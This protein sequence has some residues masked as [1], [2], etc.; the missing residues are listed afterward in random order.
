M[1]TK[2]KL[3]IKVDVTKEVKRIAR[4]LVG[5]VPASRVENTKETKPARKE[6]Y[7]KNWEEWGP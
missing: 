4:T 6:K 7:K 5:Q 3:K 2:H 1:A